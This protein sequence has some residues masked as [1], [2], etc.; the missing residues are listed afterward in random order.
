[1]GFQIGLKSS[2]LFFTVESNSGLNFPRLQWSGMRNCTAV[3]S[4]EAFLQVCRISY[5]MMRLCS[6]ISENINIEKG[7]KKEPYFVLSALPSA[8]V[9]A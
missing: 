7:H 3:M 4:G 6:N 9:V 1:M 2:R 5:I 8:V